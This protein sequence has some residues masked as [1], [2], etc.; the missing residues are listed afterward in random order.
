MGG[1]GDGAGGMDMSSMEQMMEC[2]HFLG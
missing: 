2:D 1:M